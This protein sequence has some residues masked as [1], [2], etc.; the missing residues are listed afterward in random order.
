MSLPC[1]WSVVHGT[2][3]PPVPCVM[4]DVPSIVVVLTVRRACWASCVPVVMRTAACPR[5]MHPSSKWWGGKNGWAGAAINSI[6]ASEPSSEQCEAAAA[7]DS[8]PPVPRRPPPA[9]RF[10]SVV[11]LRRSPFVVATLWLCCL[12]M[13]CRLVGVVAVGNCE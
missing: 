1:K 8:N 9:L 4:A 11:V 10:P 2:A 5:A 12:L 7:A 13:R 3:A 6:A